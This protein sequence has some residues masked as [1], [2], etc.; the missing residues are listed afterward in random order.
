MRR[1]RGGAN[2]VIYKHTEEEKFRVKRE[3]VISNS[4]KL[5]TSILIEL[6]EKNPELD[7]NLDSLGELRELIKI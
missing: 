7:M 5:I 1:L 3:A 4:V 6:Q 2:S